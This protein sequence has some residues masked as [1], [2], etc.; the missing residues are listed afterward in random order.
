MSPPTPCRR[1]RSTVW[2]GARSSSA[3]RSSRAENSRSPGRPGPP[4]ARRP[5]RG[6]PVDVQPQEWGRSR[7]SPRRLNGPVKALAA[8]ADGKK[9][10]VGGQFTKVGTAKRLRFAA[11]DVATG[12]LLSAAP[13]FDGG[14]NA[15]TVIGSTVYAGGWFTAVGTAPRSR[16]AAFNSTTGKLSG[17]AP[18]RGRHRRRAG[19]HPRQ[20]EGDRRRPVLPAQRHEGLGARRA[21]RE[22][23]RSKALGHQQGG[24][25][26]WPN[27][28]ITSLVADKTT[29]YG[30]GFAFGGGNFEGAFAVNPSDG[31]IKWIEDCHGDTY[32]VAP[33]GG[34]VY[35]VGHA[36]YCSNAAAS[37]RHPSGAIT[38][39]SP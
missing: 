6:Q 12:K 22:I 36:H 38:G 34:V 31:S 33:I 15:L 20:V 28:G 7:A 26:L 17:W 18:R 3:T 10:F 37:R 11:F 2:C 9:L 1:L 19:R 21:R 35:T 14:V 23:R 32:S 39:P 24:T 25:R 29:I 16:L 13:A 8:S 5:C 27:A 4:R 30:S